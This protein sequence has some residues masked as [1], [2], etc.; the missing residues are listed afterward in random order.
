MGNKYYSDLKFIKVKGNFFSESRILLDDF[1][2]VV[3]F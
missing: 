1:K 2:L 3:L